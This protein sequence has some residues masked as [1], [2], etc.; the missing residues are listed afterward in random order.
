MKP[1]VHKAASLAVH[2]CGDATTSIV[3]DDHDVL[4]L[5]HVHR[6]LQHGQVVC[7]LRRRQIGDV[8]VNK[9][10]PGI[11]IDNFVGR[12]PAVG[13]TDPQVFRGLL[14]FKAFEETRIRRNL[15]GG[16]GTVVRFQMIEHE[17]LDVK[18]PSRSSH[19]GVGLI[20]LTP[21][22]TSS[23]GVVIGSPRTMSR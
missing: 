5:D 16:P 8:A 12:N 13:A 21:A 23:S 19:Y 17:P 3:T 22:T 9:Q 15:A 10:F 14:A 20:V 1:V 11:E 18:Q 2:G 6:E 4:D 7:V